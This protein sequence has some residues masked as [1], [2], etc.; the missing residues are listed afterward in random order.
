VQNFSFAYTPYALPLLAAAFL[1]AMVGAYAWTRRQAWGAKPL[2]YITAAMTIWALVYALEIMAVETAGKIWWA[3]IQYLG[4]ALTPYLWLA[5]ALEYAGRD[6]DWWRRPLRLFLLFAVVTIL[7]VFTNEYHSLIWAEIGLKQ[8]AVLARPL[9]DISYG[10]WFW[11]HTAVAYT[12]LLIGTAALLRYAWRKQELYRAQATAVAI[13]A[14]VPWAANIAYLSGLTGAFPLD[15]TPFAFTVTALCLGWAVLGYQL[16]DI[17]PIARDLI[18]DRMREGVIVINNDGRIA[19][20]NQAAAQIIGLPPAQTVGK[21]AAEALAPWPHL[22]AHLQTGAAVRDVIA[23]GRGEAQIKYQAH[24]APLADQ[25]ERPLG[26]IITIQTEGAPPGEPSPPAPLTLV[27]AETAVPPAGPAW[28]QVVLNFFVPPPLSDTAFT[29]GENPTL[30]ALLERAFTAMLR[31]ATMFSA[32]ALL[33]IAPRMIQINAVGPLI[34][35]IFGVF[36]LAI[37]SLTRRINFAYRVFAFLIVVYFIG[38]VELLSYGYSVEAFVIFLTLTALAVLL[39]GARIGLIIALFNFLTLT[40]VGWQIAVGAYQPIAASLLAP[41]SVQTGLTGLFVFAA[42]SV[43]LIVAIMLLL[44][45][46]K[47]AWQQEMQARNLLQQERDALD[48]RVLVRTRQLRE[49]EA[50]LRQRE[51]I[52]AAVSSS[53]E[54]LLKAQDWRAVVPI[55]LTELGRAA[56]ASRAYIFIRHGDVS[57][58]FNLVSQQYEWVAPGISPEIDNPDLQNLSLDNMFPSWVGYF[59]RGEMVSGHIK[60]FPE[61]EQDLLAAQQIHSMAVMPI[62]VNKSWW[63]FIGFDECT[64]ER[65]WTLPEIEALHIAANNLGAVIQQ[66]RQ[67]NALAYSE[68][69]QRALL[70]AIPD[71]MFRSDRNGVFLDF[72]IGSPQDLLIPP[73]QIAGLTAAEVLPAELAEMYTD[74][75]RQA[76]QTGKEA[77]YEYSLTLNGQLVDFEARTVPAGL[78]EVLTIVRNVTERRRLEA[79]T[80]ALAIEK[81]RSQLLRNFVQISS[82]EFRT[83]LTIIGMALSVLNYSQDEQ[84][85]KNAIDRAQ[86]QI[87]RIVRLLDMTLRMTQLDSDDLTLDYEPIDLRT[88]LPA[89]VNK[90]QNTAENQNVQ[91]ACYAAPNLPPLMAD[92]NWLQEALVCLLDNGARFT[93]AGGAVTLQAFQQGEQIAIA[94]Q[95]TGI[96]I[97]PENL[98]R[99]FERFW[100]QDDAHTLPGF[101]LGLPIVQK[102]AAV[103]HGRVEVKSAVAQ[104]STFT[105]ILPLTPP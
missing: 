105:L 14:L 34:S 71:L 103:H 12:L 78:D 57:G 79:Q 97:S 13:A 68:A 33:V 101:G 31:F 72:H 32:V 70:S 86:R 1:A 41:Q 51:A 87:P 4:I 89:V 82:H 77:V 100:R 46:V 19:D 18:L 38:L 64:G 85:R 24:I 66:Q 65:L 56:A 55:I 95:D 98:T 8:N 6:L 26:Q 92:S 67:K 80:A 93:P 88:F 11:L 21:P 3:K 53:S 30:T 91:L 47:R 75:I 44:Q 7:L 59:D 94:I 90:I 69:Q 43:A 73:E 62:I 28:L 9:L 20:I 49:S 10:F 50:N 37:L 54:R 27:D 42:N 2:A 96:G 45:S 22:L 39:Q 17:V 52:L 83:P 84:K 74:Y 61:D 99:V 76:L 63:G 58:A 5:F 16:V 36:I 102:I 29:A 23:I 40:L 48:E 104:G 25:W 15:L 35:F 60:D 81:E